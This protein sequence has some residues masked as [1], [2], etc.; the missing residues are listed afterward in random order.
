MTVYDLVFVLFAAAAFTLGALPFGRWIGLVAGRVDVTRRGSGNIGATNVARELGLQWGALTLALD[1][2]KGFIPVFLISLYCPESRAGEVLV[3]LC[4]LTGDQF[5]MFVGFKGGKGV[6]TAL[7]VCLAAAPVQALM[8]LSVF[9][10][11]AGLSGFVSLGS[12]IA[13][14]S[15]PL[16]FAVTG[17]PPLWIAGS[18]F[19]AG[20]ICF[21]H[22]GN[23]RRLK[24]GTERR[25]R[26]SKDWGLRR[27]AQDKEKTKPA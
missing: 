26:K 14:C 5:S 8:A 7:G 25:W 18:V 2:M 6:A 16:F 22:K 17:M 3:G 20:L 4:A 15:L 13:A 21:R 1:V 27:K 10:F 12:I 19:M 24:K 11:V 23:I 9:V